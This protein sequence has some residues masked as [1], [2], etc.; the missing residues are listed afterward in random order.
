M[1]KNDLYIELINGGY[2]TRKELE[3]VCEMWGYDLENLNRA[4]YSRYG[5]RDYEQLTKWKNDLEEVN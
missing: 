3:L 1:S 4:I 2:F 5:A